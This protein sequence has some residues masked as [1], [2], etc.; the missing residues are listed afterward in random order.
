MSPEQWP[1][2]AAVIM[3]VL[4]QLSSPSLGNVAPV[5]AMSGR[6]AM[7]MANR[8]VLPGKIK[9]ATLEEVATSQKKACE[10]ARGAL[11]SMHNPW[12][13]C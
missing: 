13:N 1:E 11:D 4:N 5:T 8:L 3:L 9:A 10:R 12:L 2:A 6:P 7:Q